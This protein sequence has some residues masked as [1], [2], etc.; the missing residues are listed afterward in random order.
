MKTRALLLPILALCLGLVAC[1]PPGS[2]KLG[3]LAVGDKAYAF[4]LSDATGRKMSLKDL[5]PGWSLL[6]VYYRGYWCEA[7]RNQLLDLKEDQAKFSDLKTAIACVSVEDVATLAEF[8]AT[9]RFPFPLLSDPSLR[10][11]D[12]YGFRHEKG[13]EGKDISKPGIVIVGPDKKVIYKYLGRSP[14]DLPSNQQLLDFL[15]DRLAATKR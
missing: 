2:E 7:C 10:A 5:K 11:M 3:G 6:L 13:H 12:A 15:R 1:G 8:N 9:W 14:V 4:N